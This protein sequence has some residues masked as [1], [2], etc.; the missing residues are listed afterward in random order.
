[1]FPL[2]VVTWD[3]GV[4][5]S[6]VALDF[7]LSFSYVYIPQGTNKGRSNGMHRLHIKSEVDFFTRKEMAPYSYNI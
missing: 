7:F 2:F 1:L 4:W 3:I 5:D 6:I